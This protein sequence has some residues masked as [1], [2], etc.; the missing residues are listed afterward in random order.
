MKR[1]AQFSAWVVMAGCLFGGMVRAQERYSPMRPDDGIISANQHFYVTGTNRAELLT[2]SIWAEDTVERVAGLINRPYPQAP[3][4]TLTRIDLV[5]TNDEPPCVSMEQYDSDAGFRQVLLLRNVTRREQP[6]ALR[7]LCTLILNR[8]ARAARPNTPFIRDPESAVPYWMVEG[9]ARHGLPVWRAA[10]REA[11]IQAWNAGESFSIENILKGTW[12]EP[13]KSAAGAEWFEWLQDRPDASELFHAAL[14]QTGAGEQLTGAWLPEQCP[15]SGTLRDWNQAWSLHLAT[16]ASSILTPGALLPEDVTRLRESL[17]IRPEMI[18]VAAQ[19]DVPYAYQLGDMIEG[20]SAFWMPALVEAIAA[21]IQEASIGRAP[22]LQETAR[23]Y[24]IY[25][26]AVPQQRA[27][28]WSRLW[29]GDVSDAKLRALLKEA[30]HSLL[31][32]EARVQAGQA[33]ADSI[34]YEEP[35]REMRQGKDEP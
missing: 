25:L 31:M 3:G 33:D 28:F 23:K 12:P 16:L 22:A 32:L 30:D 19:E 18:S 1:I 4:E 2:I 35:P 14:V 21:R 29:H 11:V 34:T 6:D 7:A 9:M 13:L 27:G 26:N 17:V 10:G 20:R 8:Y 5:Y 24:L 15:G